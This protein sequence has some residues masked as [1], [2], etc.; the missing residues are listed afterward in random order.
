MKSVRLYEIEYLNSDSD[1][2]TDM[3]FDLTEAESMR[4]S[5]AYVDYTGG[6]RLKFRRLVKDTFHADLERHTG[7]AIKTLK[8]KILG[9]PK[10]V[11][12]L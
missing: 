1:Y 3:T 7:V 2:P 12:N 8:C 10:G 9:E 11:E 5:R 4:W 6:N